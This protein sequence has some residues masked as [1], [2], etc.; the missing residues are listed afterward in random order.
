[1]T[2]FR[3]AFEG[4]GRFPERGRPRVVWL[5]I[6]EGRESVLRLGVAVAEGLRARRLS[7]DDRPLSPHL[8]LA[9]VPD[10]ATLADARAVTAAVD[11]LR[12]PRLATDVG[13]IVLM[14]SVLSR[15]GP[16]YTPRSH[17]PLGDRRAG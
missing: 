3:L 5:A 8:T 13:E 16:T 12:P 14:Q 7:F 15:G 17:A 11:A 1:V 4:A 2:P 6:A 10:A 9:R